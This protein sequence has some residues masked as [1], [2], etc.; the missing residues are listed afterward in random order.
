MNRFG[1][2]IGEN[3]YRWTQKGYTVCVLICSLALIFFALLSMSKV[4]ETVQ[5]KPK[6]K[7]SFGQIFNVIKTN[8]QLRV[9]MLFA[10]LSNA[11]FYTT[12][13][14]KDYFF[15]IVLENSKAQSLFNTFRFHRERTFCSRPRRARRTVSP[16]G[17]CMPFSAKSPSSRT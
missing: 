11:G 1:V 13:G 14:V 3:N 12:S 17:A 5:I 9:F 10:M 2:L 8:D 15:G 4:K 16:F 6:E 7:F